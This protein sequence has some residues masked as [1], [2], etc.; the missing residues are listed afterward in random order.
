MEFLA[1]TLIIVHQ[2]QS[3]SKQIKSSITIVDDSLDGR[4]GY[5]STGHDWTN[6]FMMD[7]FNDTET[8]LFAS[9]VRWTNGRDYAFGIYCAYSY[10]LYNELFYTDSNS[11]DGFVEGYAR[12]NS[13][14]SCYNTSINE[15]NSM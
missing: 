1:M 15:Y 2:H 12:R 11:D 3:G 9:R 8:H 5:T 7:I 6:T 13:E 10:S 14:S 4:L